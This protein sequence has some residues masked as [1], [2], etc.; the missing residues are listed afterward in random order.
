MRIIPTTCAALLLASLCGSVW[1]KSPS[2]FHDIERINSDPAMHLS[3]MPQTEMD[4]V[5]GSVAPVV[6]AGVAAVGTAIANGANYWIN[7]PN[8]TAGGLAWS[9]G[10]GF[11]AGTVGGIAATMPP[12]GAVLATGASAFIPMIPEPSGFKCGAAG[13]AC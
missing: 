6:I 8:P 7:T 11:T 5:E 2:T 10:T 13:I 4:S 12:V 1:A 3:Q 9:A